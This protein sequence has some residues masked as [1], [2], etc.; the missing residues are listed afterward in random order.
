ML[1]TPAG[2]CEDTTGNL[3]IAD[4]SNNV[5]RKVDV[6]GVISTIAGNTVMGFSGDSGV[7]TLAELNG[8]NS[9]MVTN[10]GTFYIVDEGNH[11]I[12]KMCLNTDS[13]FGYIRTPSNTPVTAG[14]V[15]AFRRQHTHNGLNDTLGF[16]NIQPNG[17]Y[18]FPNIY[19]NNYL[20]KAIADTNLYPNS[21]GTY[22]GSRSNCY[23]WD[24]SSVVLFD[25]C[26]PATTLGDS[27]TINMLSPSAGAGII[28]G[29]ITCTPDFGTRWGGGVSV[30]GAPLKGIDVKLGKNPGGQVA[31]RT[32]T[33]TSGNYSFTNLAA[34]DYSI[35][36][37]VPNFPMANVI[38]VTLTTAQQSVLN[39][40][41]IDSA[42][43]R[44]DTTAHTTMTHT[45]A[46]GLVDVKV[47]PNPAKSVL[48]I[49]GIDSEKIVCNLFDVNGNVVKDVVL[50]KGIHTLNLSEISEGVYNLSISSN[51]RVVNRRIVILR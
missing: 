27:I 40:Y 17:Y 22:Y 36:V 50:T 11:C 12:R 9:V 2:I 47:Y 46:A 37:D 19:G 26:N 8:P 4:A 23:Q 30:Q 14:V 6:S 29:Q 13:V 45:V 5:V 43:V 3:Y 31:A 1:N 33:D 20:I 10:S 21:I 42:Y 44:T 41:Y 51:N 24:S 35:Y 15:Y 7:A 18:S 28:S 49:E 48:Y 32:T 25:P 16:V 38:S 34:G 39:D